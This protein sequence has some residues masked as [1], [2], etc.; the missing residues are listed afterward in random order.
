MNYAA[1]R[2]WNNNYWAQ[3]IP[4]AVWLNYFSEQYEFYNGHEVQIHQ[5]LSTMQLTLMQSTNVQELQFYLEHEITNRK[6]TV[7]YLIDER[8]RALY[9]LKTPQ[10]WDKSERLKTWFAMAYAHQTILSDDDLIQLAR[11]LELEPATFLEASL[12]YGRESL[13]ERLLT[14][15]PLA[16]NS[17]P[18]DKAI[19][20]YGDCLHT[21]TL[22]GHTN[23]VRRLKLSMGSQPYR[24]AFSHD[25][26]QLIHLA[27]TQNHVAL[28]EDYLAD[29]EKLGCLQDMLNSSDYLLLQEAGKTS[30]TLFTRLLSISLQS[31]THPSKPSRIAQ[32]FGSNETIPPLIER[33]LKTDLLQHAFSTGQ[34]ETICYI[35]FLAKLHDPS[36]RIIQE[37]LSK[38]DL[39]V[40]IR[41]GHLNSI[42]LFIE[43]IREYQPKAIGFTLEYVA[44]APNDKEGYEAFF[45]LLKHWKSLQKNKSLPPQLRWPWLFYNAIANEDVDA[46]QYLLELAEEYEFFNQLELFL[47]YALTSILSPKNKVIIQHLLQFVKKHPTLTKE[48]LNKKQTEVM[49]VLA[50]ID[51]SDIANIISTF[52]ESQDCPMRQL[53]EADNFL[54]YLQA[55][56][57]SAFDHLVMLGERYGINIALMLQSRTGEIFRSALGYGRIDLARRWLALAKQHGLDVGSIVRSMKEPLFSFEEE[58]RCSQTVELI[59]SLYHEYSANN[60]IRQYVYTSRLLSIAT[61]HGFTTSVQR[62]LEIPELFEEASGENDYIGYVR[63]FVLHKL[64]YLKQQLETNSSGYPFDLPPSESVDLYFF[65]LD[66]LLTSR[67]SQFTND[68]HFLLSLPAIQKIATREKNY[69]HPNHLLQTALRCNNKA[70]AK[71]LLQIPEVKLLA[72]KDK[73]YPDLRKKGKIRLEELGINAI[74]DRPSLTATQQAFFQTPPPPEKKPSWI[75]S[76]CCLLS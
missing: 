69:N 73:Y 61:S 29:A 72:Q 64:T 14:M 45:Y 13:C 19:L 70:A 34:V 9:S 36:H 39:K 33:L 57:V 60:L 47:E 76:H 24:T 37:A 41:A 7:Q 65:I 15:T 42:E 62:L 11:T 21:A 75:R 55:T 59:L 4:M 63:P 40:A 8:M 68:I 10:D 5:Y 46:V 20:S 35:I 58:D 26:Y 3:K 30:T 71:Q 6:T 2:R 16:K 23:L 43:L 12:V 67:Q 22:Y 49:T 56:T 25:S 32:M 48:V 53:L 52:L 31:S 28:V 74:E 27:M 51:H 50:Y 17:D 66:Y 54:L 44:D 38:I 18:K 1:Q